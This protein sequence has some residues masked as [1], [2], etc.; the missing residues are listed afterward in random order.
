MAIS[1]CGTHA[2]VA[3]EVEAC[4]VGERT[5]TRR[6]FARVRPDELLTADRGFYSFGGV[7]R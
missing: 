3:A 7:L 5:M 6:L 4:S 1:E 2:F